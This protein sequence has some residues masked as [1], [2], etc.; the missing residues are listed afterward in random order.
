MKINWPFLLLL[1][2]IGFITFIMYFVISMTT[3]KKY[4]YQL[5]TE[6]YYKKE[7]EFNEELRAL[8]NAKNME[9]KLLSK[10][11]REGWLFSFPPQANITPIKGK[12][13]LYRPSNQNLDFEIPIVLKENDFLIPDK[14]FV[15]GRWDITLYWQYNKEPYIYK[16]S[17]VY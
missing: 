6:D 1:S 14:Y 7:L 15:A 8:N 5:V 2:M 10:R 4:N 16:E 11:V 3:Q 17:I 9:E 12:A 13:I